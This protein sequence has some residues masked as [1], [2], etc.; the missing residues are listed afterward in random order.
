MRTH[1]DSLRSAARLE[2]RYWRKR[3]DLANSPHIREIEAAGHRLGI[4]CRA[5]AGDALREYIWRKQCALARH[6][7]TRAPM[8]TIVNHGREFRGMSLQED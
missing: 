6:Y 8:F 2:L 7:R 5:D 4:H 1:I 3:L